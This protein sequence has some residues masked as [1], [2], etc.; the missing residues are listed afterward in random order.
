MGIV[1]PAAGSSFFTAP[2]YEPL[3]ICPSSGCGDGGPFQQLCL[4]LVTIGQPATACAAQAKAKIETNPTLLYAASSDGK[5]NAYV[6]TGADGTL[7]VDGVG[8]AGLL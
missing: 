6:R 5:A 3:Y 4:E 8:G 1:T 2:W 7:F